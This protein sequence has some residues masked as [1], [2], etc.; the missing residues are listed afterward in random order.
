[1]LCCQIQIEAFIIIIVPAGG[2]VSL[3]RTIT[4]TAFMV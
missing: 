2:T 1:M 3:S 4:L